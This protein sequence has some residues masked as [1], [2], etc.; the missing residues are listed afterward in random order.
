MNERV[1]LVS[2]ENTLNKAGA[3]LRWQFEKCG[4]DPERN[5][6]VVIVVET[7]TE[8]SKLIDGFLRDY[9]AKTM[10]RRDDQPGNIAVHGVRMSVIVREP[11]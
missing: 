2:A 10:R 4:V 8:R 3:H 1:P 5:V 7:E 9:D 6:M 11:Q